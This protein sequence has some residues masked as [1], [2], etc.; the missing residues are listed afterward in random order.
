MHRRVQVIVSGIVQG[1]AFRHHTC[2]E[3]VRHGVSGWVRNLPDGTVEGC[4]EGEA[5]AV[6][7]LVD[8]CHHGPSLA[9]VDRV[10]VTDVPYQGE[11]TGFFIR[12]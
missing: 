4:F 12:S 7:T 9:R 5:T 3:A 1:V 8:W 2:R 6:T 11:F 10:T